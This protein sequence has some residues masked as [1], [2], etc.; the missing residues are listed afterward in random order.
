MHKPLIAVVQ[1][2]GGNEGIGG[3][4]CELVDRARLALCHEH[5]VS[6]LKAITFFLSIV[7][8]S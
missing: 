5:N 7:E 4:I 2:S 1:S 3:G 6:K 8:S